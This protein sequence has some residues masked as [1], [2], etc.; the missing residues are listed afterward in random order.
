LNWPIA[1]LCVW[2]QPSSGDNVAIITEA[3][4]VGLPAF[5]RHSRRVASGLLGHDE[6]MNEDPLTLVV[7]FDAHSDT[8]HELV[9][10]LLDLVPL[11]TAEPG[12]LLYELHEDLNDP[13]RFTFVET[14]ANPAAHAAHDLTDHVQAI[15]ADIPRLTRHRVTIQRLRKLL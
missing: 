1:A 7:T 14:W 13:N 12:C 5:A 8:R 2:P 15:I 9:G 4:V 3:T 10:R 11:T 6:A